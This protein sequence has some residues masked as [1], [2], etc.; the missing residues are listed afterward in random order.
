[1]TILSAKKLLATICLT[2]GLL[3][4]GF[5]K[6]QDCDS[7]VYF[8]PFFPGDGVLH[9]VNHTHTFTDVGPI[10][11]NAYNKE[12]QLIDDQPYWPTIQG[13]QWVR[14]KPG[15]SGAHS[16]RVYVPDGI[17]VVAFRRNGLDGIDT[18]PVDLLVDNPPCSTTT[19]PPEPETPVDTGGFSWQDVK[20]FIDVRRYVH[21][22]DGV[23]LNNPFSRVAADSCNQGE[24]EHTPYRS[25]CQFVFTLHVRWEGGTDQGTLSFN[26]ITEGRG[27]EGNVDLPSRIWFSGS[28]A[29][30]YQPASKSCFCVHYYPTGNVDDGARHGSDWVHLQS[31]LISAA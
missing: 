15:L 18:L 31:T 16:I 12:G 24:P 9:I 10:S 13:A 5:A 6:A 11:I 1:M 2:I 29:N 14:W 23:Y 8:V 17:S 27:A 7:D 4:P 3:V 19:S 25:H 20:V 30:N 26:T 21:R 28:G 22:G